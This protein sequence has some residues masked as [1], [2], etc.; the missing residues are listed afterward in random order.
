MPARLLLN[1]LEQRTAFQGI[2][3]VWSPTPWTAATPAGKTNP[4]TMALVA[5]PLLA[6][7]GRRGAQHR[8]G[9]L[10]RSLPAPINTLLTRPEPLLSE[11]YRESSGNQSL[12]LISAATP[13][14]IGGQ[15]LGAV[16]VTLDLSRIQADLAAV[17]LYD[18]GYLGLLSSQGRWLAHPQPDRWASRR[19]S[20]RR[21]HARRWARAERYRWR[22][23]DGRWMVL[24]PIQLGETVAPWAVAVSVDADELAADALTVVRNTLITSAWAL[25]PC[26]R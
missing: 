3:S 4:C 7:S 11:S 23:D 9:R 16:G 15:F 13:V 14:M 8:H 21:R 19:R 24:A 17:K 26:W 10:Q 22:S 6:A 1:A 5:L 12:T 2:W 20:C 18:T 25:S